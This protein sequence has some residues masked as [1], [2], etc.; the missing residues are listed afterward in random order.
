LATQDD[1]S[2]PIIARILAVPSLRAKYLA[3]V[4]EIAEKSFDWQTLGPVVKG[5]RAL[6]SDDVAR[7]TRK[8]FST[9]QFLTGT[10]DEPGPGSLRS[11]IDQRRAFLLNWSEPAATEASQ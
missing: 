6:I 5:Y 2:K 8:L 9:E 1:A 11:F 3:Y 10:A 4:R 7:D